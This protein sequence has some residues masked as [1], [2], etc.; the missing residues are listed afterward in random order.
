MAG[1]RGAAASSGSCACHAL[2]GLSGADQVPQL[3][4]GQAVATLLKRCGDAL[5][6]KARAS[7][8]A[9]LAAEQQQCL[10]SLCLLEPL[11]GAR[12]GGCAPQ[13][14]AVLSEALQSLHQQQGGGAGGGLQ[15]GG[16]GD[17]AFSGPAAEALTLQAL[18]AWKLF[19]RALAAHASSLLHRLGAQVAVVLLPLLEAAHEGGSPVLDAAVEVR[20]AGKARRPGME[21]EGGGGAQAR[22]HAWQ[23]A[24]AATPAL[25][26]P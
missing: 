26:A 1:P 13:V 3:L 16:A 24:A 2:A 15:G 17:S 14:M 18:Q 21:R 5:T 10:R 7:C 20:G 8:R 4:H 19:V 9:G 25:A 12:I 11:L 6:H 22:V 23:A